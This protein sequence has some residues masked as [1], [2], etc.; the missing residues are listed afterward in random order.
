[1]RSKFV[2]ITVTVMAF[3]LAYWM[4]HLYSLALRDAAFLDGWILLAAMALQI[5]FHVRNVRPQWLRGSASAWLW[6]HTYTG[7]F[8][9]LMFALH[10]RM[11][12]PDTVFEWVHWIVFVIVTLSGLFGAYLNGAVPRRLDQRGDPVPVD[13]LSASQAALAERARRLAAGS[14]SQTGSL[15]I[16]D[17][18][19]ATLYAFFARPRNVLAHLRSSRWPRRRLRFELSRLEGEVDETG[20]ETLR[21]IGALIDE[22]DKLD[23]LHAHASVL[24]SWLIIHVP[25][26]Y[27]LVV[28]T[29]LHVLVVYAYRSGSA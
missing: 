9:V 8:V 7:W 1:M 12:P 5:L 11:T 4:T 10:S 14:I 16:A 24:R 28:L 21:E 25:A 20:R 3:L 15:A 27:A 18:Y 6:I 26:V 23:F 29:V 13:D 2:G 19:A 22:K 17:F